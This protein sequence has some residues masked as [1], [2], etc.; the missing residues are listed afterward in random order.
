MQKLWFENRFGK[1]QIDRGQ[2]PGNSH[3]KSQKIMKP[4]AN[5]RKPW[6]SMARISIFRHE[7]PWFCGKIRFANARAQGPTNGKLQC[8]M[9]R[10]QRD[11]GPRI[12]HTKTRDPLK[13]PKFQENPGFRWQGC[14]LYHAFFFPI[15]LY[16]RTKKES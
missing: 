6:L 13:T 4:E 12:S 3:K 5:S 14:P 9:A 16:L 11:R 1:L 7:L 2:G 10:C 8:A 15:N